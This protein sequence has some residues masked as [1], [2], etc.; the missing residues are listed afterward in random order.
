MT[1][2][3]P[4]IRFDM[5]Q[6]RLNDGF[7]NIICSVEGVFQKPE[8]V[9]LVGNS[10]AELFD[11]GLGRFTGGRARLAVR[12]D[13]APVF[14]RAWPLPYALRERVDAELDAMLRAG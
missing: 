12:A 9:I 7:L 6:D 11:G 5:I 14:C 8:L 4:E 1:I 3:V 10:Y 2:F 13:A